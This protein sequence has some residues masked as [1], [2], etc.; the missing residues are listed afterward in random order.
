MH[1]LAVRCLDRSMTSQASVVGGAGWRIMD[2]D[3]RTTYRGIRNGLLAGRPGQPLVHVRV[4]DR[5]GRHGCLRGGV[6]SGNLRG[7]TAAGAAGDR[8][9]MAPSSRAPARAANISVERAG[10]ENPFE[11]DTGGRSYNR[12]VA[13]GQWRMIAGACLIFAVQVEGARVVHT[14][15]VRTNCR[16]GRV[17]WAAATPI[18][19]LAIPFLLNHAV[20]EQRRHG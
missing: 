9:G 3:G 17:V 10:V 15:L 14:T 11:Y 7:S 2:R 19:Q 16:L 18:H 4:R 13:T 1:G 8:G 20:T 5:H 6:G 12:L